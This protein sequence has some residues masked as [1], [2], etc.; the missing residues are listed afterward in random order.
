M[1]QAYKKHKRKQLFKRFRAIVILFLV[2]I[3][4]KGLSE[5]GK[6]KLMGYTYDSGNTVWEMAEKYCPEN[7]DIRE[8]IAEI[9]SLNGIKNSTV[10]A[11]SVYK[12][13]IYE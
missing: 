5:Y 2:L 10:H 13:P 11:G 12:I 3:G 7:M 9:E 8:L 6:P 1:T 4:I